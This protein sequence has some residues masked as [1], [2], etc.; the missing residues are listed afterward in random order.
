M[1]EVTHPNFLGRSTY[2]IGAEHDRNDGSEL[3]IISPENGSHTEA[4]TQSALWALSW[5][6]EAQA[7]STH[8]MQGT[9]ADLIAALPPE[10]ANRH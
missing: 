7:T 3:R 8:L 6:I 10:A 9:V 4:L 5:A 2:L 1:C